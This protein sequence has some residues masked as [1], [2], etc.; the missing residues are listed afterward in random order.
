MS[1]IFFK[2]KMQDMGIIA[3][4]LGDEIVAELY[5]A[6]ADVAAMTYNKAHELASERLNSTRMD[7]VNALSMRED[8]TAW[9][10]ELDPKMN[11]VDDGFGSR[12]M[13]P[14][15]AQGPASKQTKDGTHRYTV[16]PMRQRTAP[17]N[18]ANPK[19]VE[20]ARALREAIRK[21]DWTE[22]RRGPDK[23]GGLT[24]VDRLKKDPRLHPHMQ[25][26]V[27]VRQFDPSAETESGGLDMSKL[28]SSTHTTF[29]VAS[30]SQD[31]GEMWVHPGV[32][33]ANIMRDTAEWAEQQI[34]R[35]ISEIVFD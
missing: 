4:D 8:G 18:P 17:V 12:P 21:G 23:Q 15:L 13:L 25:G 1:D 10:I 19:H 20:H 14:G 29:R 6:V 33:A 3:D 28:I 11:W 2:A 35:I 9:I 30:E 22:V 34:V 31:P 26:L 24:V 32:Q 7:F 16:I 5:A 27:R